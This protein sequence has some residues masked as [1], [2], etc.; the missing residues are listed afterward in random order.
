VQ[1]AQVELIGPP[2][3]ISLNFAKAMDDGAFGFACV[4]LLGDSSPRFDSELVLHKF[5]FL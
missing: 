2:V 3:G 5:I 1:D 4:A